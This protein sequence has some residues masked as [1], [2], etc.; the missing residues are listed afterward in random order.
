MFFDGLEKKD[1][2]IV[3][4]SV[5]MMT[6][7]HEK[8][9]SQAIESVLAQK[10]TYSYEI[11]ISDDCSEDSTR[12]ILKD[13]AQKYPHIIKLFLNEKNQGISK[14]NYFTR[15]QC[16][17]RYIATLSGD[18]YWIDNQKLQ[19][20]VEFLDEHPEILA[21]VTSVEGRYEDEEQAFEVYP[22]KKYRGKYIS[23]NMFL[24]GATIGTHGMMMRNIYLTEEGREYFSLVPKASPYI[25]DTTECY[26]ILKKSPI[27]SMDINGVAYRVRK[28]KTNEKN[29]NSTNAPIIKCKRVIDLY[30][31]L[32]MY[33]EGEIDFFRVYKSKV[34][35]LILCLISTFDINQVREVYKSIP[36]KY[37]KRML[38]FRAIPKSI[39]SFIKIIMR[40]IKTNLTK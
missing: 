20:Q 33:F 5:A 1:D 18:D 24:H 34:A 23:L 28:N 4:V 9:V 35:L 21:T 30:N 38:L 31:Q 3:D 39:K 16:S 15:L 17:G 32:D 22:K 40:K 14:N 36:V 26:L 6:Y 27:Y 7:F 25:D 29:Y 10:T 12:K 37:R 13:Y 11:I 2:D 8:Y 19:K